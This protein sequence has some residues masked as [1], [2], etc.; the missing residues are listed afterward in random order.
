AITPTAITESWIALEGALFTVIRKS[1]KDAAGPIAHPSGG[2]WYVP[3][4][5]VAGEPWVTN[6]GAQ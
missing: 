6:A 1:K 5:P 3:R 2:P 4:N